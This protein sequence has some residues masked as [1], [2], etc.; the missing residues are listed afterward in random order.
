MITSV[1]VGNVLAQFRKAI[2]SNLADNKGFKPNL[3]QNHLFPERGYLR[4][5]CH[6]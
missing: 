5:M 1:R 4:H 2:L 3:L 6:W